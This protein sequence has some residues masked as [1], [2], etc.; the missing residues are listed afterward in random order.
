[1]TAK[2]TDLRSERVLLSATGDSKQQIEKLL[3]ERGSIAAFAI[4]AANFATRY[5]AA[6]QWASSKWNCS[7]PK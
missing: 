1:M 4:T 3:A 7:P 6:A 2:R 5:S